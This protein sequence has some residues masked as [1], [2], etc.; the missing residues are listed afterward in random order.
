MMRVRC[1]D[2]VFG[3]CRSPFLFDTSQPRADHHANAFAQARALAASA[4]VGHRGIEYV[5]IV[6]R[7]TALQ[8][9][10]EARGNRGNRGT[11]H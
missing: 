6:P 1:E 5:S 8:V 2:L 9:T 10:F 4:V 7:L 11:C 3:V